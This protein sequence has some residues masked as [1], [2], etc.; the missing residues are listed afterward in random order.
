MHNS[1]VI[2][3]TIMNNGAVRC[4]PLICRPISGIYSNANVPNG[5]VHVATIPAG[6]SNISITEMKHSINLLGNL[7]NY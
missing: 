2:S 3:G 6:A 1:G 5:Y 7:C 4:G